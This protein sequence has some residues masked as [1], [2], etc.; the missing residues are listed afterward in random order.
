MVAETYSTHYL[1]LYCS[2]A[3]C[4]LPTAHYSL[5]TAHCSLLTALLLTTHC[6]LPTAHYLLLTTHYSLLT[7]HYSVLTTGCRHGCYGAKEQPLWP[8]VTR[9][10]GIPSLVVIG[11]DGDSVSQPVA[12][13]STQRLA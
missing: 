12:A 4:S 2:T 3:Y 10:N 9:R 8:Q 1:L 6:P 5:L 7:A 11:P 13:V